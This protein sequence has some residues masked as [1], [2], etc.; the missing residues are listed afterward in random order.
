MHNLNN[1]FEYNICDST[2]SRAREYVLSGGDLP[3]LFFASSQSAG[4]GRR[5]KSFYSPDATGLY[6]TLAIPYENNSRNNV[7][8]TTAVSVAVLR[9]L[10]PITKKRLSIKWV[11]DILADG[12]K[13]AGILCETA[14]DPQTKIIKAII[15][16]IGVNLTTSIF[17]DDISD[18]ATCLCEE[19][20][21]RK[22]IALSICDELFKVL[23]KED[24]ASV[25]E[26]YRK[27][28]AVIGRD[29]FYIKNGI[30]YDAKA[31]SI[32]DAGG[33]IVTHPDG[34]KATLTSG[35]ITLRIK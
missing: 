1:F 18:T 3:A 23:Y 27:E 19:L 29:I 17:P 11:N 30:R 22:T 34:T 35:E 8:L 13:V 7:T 21:D 5:G 4:R 9:A 28:S 25:M 20:P 10:S 14:C 12:K 24:S 6:M 2:N 33:L 32:D 31:I 15:I 26:F 16:G